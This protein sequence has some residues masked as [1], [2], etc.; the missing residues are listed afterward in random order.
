MSLTFKLWDDFLFH[1]LIPMMIFLAATKCGNW[2]VY[3]HI[4]SHLVPLLFVS[5]RS[6]YAKYMSVLQLQMQR[7][8]R[9]MVEAFENGLFVAKLGEGRFNSV[10]ADYALEVTQNKALKGKGGI[11]GLTLRGNALAR[12]FL[13]RPITAQYS[14]TFHNDLHSSST[15]TASKSP[16]ERDA[17]KNLWNV[18]VAKMNALFETSLVD[19]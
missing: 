13:A 8:P 11:I 18:S 6:T 17:K 3:Q 5:N 1:V 4:K 7:I 12:Y 2:S 15:N 9:E 14:M 10:W 16:H 19:P